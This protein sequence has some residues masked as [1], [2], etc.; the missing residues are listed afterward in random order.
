MNMYISLT[1]S[2]GS[3][4]KI[5]FISIIFMLNFCFNAIINS[6]LH[7]LREQWIATKNTFKKKEKKRKNGKKRA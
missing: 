6:A 4:L 5:K 7:G 1:E 3:L 2:D